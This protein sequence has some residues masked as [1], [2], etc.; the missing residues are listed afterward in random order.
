[1]CQVLFMSETKMNTL[2]QFFWIDFWIL[3]RS[4]FEVYK[5]IS[6]PQFD[7]FISG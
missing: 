5:G 4:K 2:Q 3:A 7:F 1:M 6:M